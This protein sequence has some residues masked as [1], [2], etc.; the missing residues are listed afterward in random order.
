MWSLLAETN[1]NALLCGWMTEWTMGGISGATALASVALL[2]YLFGRS[3]LRKR[4]GQERALAD[5]THQMIT[6]LETVSQQIRHSLAMQH[7][8]I[9]AFREKMR[10]LCEIEDAELRKEVVEQARRIL[11]PTAELSNEIVDAYEKIRKETCQL[12]R[13]KKARQT[14]EA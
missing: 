12:R 8:S 7:A 13:F 5:Q 10:A 6:Q 4:M 3:Q 2:G 1:P 9:Q 14:Q 11:E